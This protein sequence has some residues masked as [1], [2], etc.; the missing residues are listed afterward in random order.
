MADPVGPLEIAGLDEWDVEELRLAL[1]ESG[2]PAGDVT[3]KKRA[4]PP[5]DGRA[6]E[7]GTIALAIAIVHYAVP[8]VALVISTWLKTCA[9]DKHV[10]LTINGA[11]VSSAELDARLKGIIQP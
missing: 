4:A 6:Y 2:L 9:Q 3:I 8:A 10:T 11:P 7:P 1:T 5:E